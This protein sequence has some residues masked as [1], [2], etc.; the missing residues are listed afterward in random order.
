MVRKE[1]ELTKDPICGMELDLAQTVASYE[2]LGQIY[3]FC[4]H[5]CYDMFRRIP[6][7]YITH[8]AHDPKG[9][10]GHHCPTRRDS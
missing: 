3:R 7:Q 5:E 6:E 8:V 2:Y 4:S 9:H 1:N 10:W